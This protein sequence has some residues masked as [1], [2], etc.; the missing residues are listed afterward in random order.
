VLIGQSGITNR[1]RLISMAH[2]PRR[3]M[4]FVDGENVAI[5]GHELIRANGLQLPVG[6]YYRL[7]T[8]LWIPV[9]T[10]QG[11]PQFAQLS[12][13]PS[14]I[15][16]SGRSTTRRSKGI[17]QR[18]TPCGRRFGRSGSSPRCSISRATGPLSA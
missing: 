8:F 12:P 14:P 13:V 4:M 16:A 6:P 1:Q 18:R 2:T 10:A 3:W 5:R 9:I 15:S 17:S 7:D 11:R